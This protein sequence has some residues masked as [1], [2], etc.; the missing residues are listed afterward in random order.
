MTVMDLSQER[1]KSFYLPY[2]KPTAEWQER[3][4]LFP[5]ELFDPSQIKQ[6]RI[7][8]NPETAEAVFWIRNI[9]VLYGN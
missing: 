6:L 8:M 9:R 7:G 5:A 3:V 2:E 4:V 1:G